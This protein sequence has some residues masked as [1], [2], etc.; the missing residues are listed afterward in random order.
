MTAPHGVVKQRCEGRW[1]PN[2]RD[3]ERLDK[4]YSLAFRAIKL[5]KKHL[6]TSTIELADGVEQ[7]CRALKS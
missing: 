2:K 1:A 3:F 5:P 4:V 7:L 6:N